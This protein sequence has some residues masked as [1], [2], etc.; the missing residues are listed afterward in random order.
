MLDETPLARSLE[1]YRRIV[2]VAVKVFFYGITCLLLLYFERFLEALHKTHNFDPALAYVVKNATRS[3]VLVWALGISIVFALYFA[4]V[5][6][7]ERMGKGELWR[8]FFEPHRKATRSSQ[9][10]S[11]VVGRAGT[12]GAMRCSALTE[13]CSRHIR[14][15]ICSALLG[16]IRYRR[17]HGACRGGSG[18]LVLKRKAEACISVSFRDLGV[19]SITFAGG[20]P[21]RLRFSGNMS[22]VRFGTRP[23]QRSC[24]H[25]VFGDRVGGCVGL[26]F[27]PVPRLAAPINLRSATQW[28]TI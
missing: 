1:H 4:F 28:R 23:D 2:A 13:I 21:G 24:V 15:A 20:A 12:D 6:I 27:L 5:E 18:N 25:P 7:N 16:F 3:R 9:P 26:S 10:R 17:F 14:P 8:L 19:R 22:E 11:V